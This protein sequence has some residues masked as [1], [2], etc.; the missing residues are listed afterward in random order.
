MNMHSN[1]LSQQG[2]HAN[3]ALS[4]LNHQHQHSSTQ[5]PLRLPTKYAMAFGMVRRPAESAALRVWRVT[6]NHSHAAWPALSEKAELGYPNYIHSWL[7]SHDCPQ[8]SHDF[9]Q[10]STSCEFPST[11]KNICKKQHESHSPGFLAGNLAFKMAM[12]TRNIKYWWYW[13]Y[14]KHRFWK[15]PSWQ[16]MLLIHSQIHFTT[17]ALT[18]PKVNKI[19]AMLP[20]QTNLG[21][22]RQNGTCKGE[23]FI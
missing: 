11:Q 21:V 18:R 10:A 2:L 15:H 4:M 13:R 17:D 3:V 16:S 23:W 8:P 7:I 5:N 19:T 9:F 1:A 20:N 22:S 6:W 14:W 12:E